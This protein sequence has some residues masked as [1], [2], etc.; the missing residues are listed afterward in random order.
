MRAQGK[1]LLPDGL[2]WLSYF[3]GSSKSHPEISFLAYFGNFLL[4]LERLFV[5]Y[6]PSKC[7]V[8]VACLWSYMPIFLCQKLAE[9]VWIFFI[10]E[11]ENG[12]ATFIFGIFWKLFNVLPFLKMCPNFDLQYQTEPNTKNIFMAVFRD[13]WPCLFTTKLS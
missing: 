7:L 12:G 9:S 4:I 11:Y 3:A 6:W 8:W 2:D 10:A 13:L 5:V 1:K